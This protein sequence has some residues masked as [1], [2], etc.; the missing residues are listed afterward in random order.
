MTTG[1]WTV[2]DNPNTEVNSHFRAK[3]FWLGSD[4][5]TIT[6]RVSRKEKW[7]DYL[8]GHFK[9]HMSTNDLG[10]INKATLAK[11]TVKSF[12]PGVDNLVPGVDFPQTAFS[13]VYTVADEYKLLAKLLGKVK[14]HT[15]NIGVSLAEVDKLASTVLGTMQNIGRF[16]IALRYRNVTE[17]IRAFGTKAPISG[18]SFQLQGTDISGRFL[19]ARYAV[20]P[21]IQDVFSAAQAFEALSNGPRQ[22]VFKASRLVKKSIAFNGN[23]QKANMEVQAY[24]R[25][26]YEMY[27]EMNA[28]RQMGL[29]NPLSIV[30]ERLPWS[31]VWDWFMPIGTY[32][33]LIG[34]VPF[35]KGRWMVTDSFRRDCGGLLSELVDGVSATYNISSPLPKMEVHSFQQRRQVSFTPPSVPRPNFSVEGAIQGKRIGNAVALGHQLFDRLVLNRRGET[36]LN[37]AQVELSRWDDLFYSLLKKR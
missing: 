37:Q 15:Y 14:G 11:S 24:R 12:W 9:Y 28:F 20:E 16:A 18:K 2:G 19:E 32:L 27:E 29:A 33:E 30:W 5:S 17:A 26:T 21:A 35:M 13:G 7:N 25:Y 31:F 8:M 36:P 10:L 3:K 23:W 6:G 4:G 22:Q 34:Q 1:S